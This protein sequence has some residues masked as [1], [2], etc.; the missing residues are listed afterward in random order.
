MVN[1][2]E[3]NGLFEAI[4][5]NAALL[6]ED[7]NA[8]YEHGK[9]IKD[10]AV[11]INAQT[12]MI[13][14]DAVEVNRLSQAMMVSL[15]HLSANLNEMVKKIASDTK[16]IDEMLL[17][18][19]SIDELKSNIEN[20]S[21]Q[22][23]LLALNASIEAARA[24][25]AG[26]GFAVVANEIQK[27]S[28]QSHEATDAI[29]KSI[30]EVKLSSDTIQVNIKLLGKDI[31]TT[32]VDLEQMSQNMVLVEECQKNELKSVKEIGSATQ[33]QE[34]NVEKLYS[35]LEDVERQ[36]IGIRSSID[37]SIDALK[38]NS[39]NIIKLNAI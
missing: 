13:Q 5:K 9:I 3:I 19:K 2:D 28:Q 6:E 34:H 29:E 15:N 16:R 38:Y 25:E 37:S 33:V 39:E 4:N 11:I 30:D 22:I 26:K 21:D 7:A 20:V 32:L 27:L 35:S 1:L 14:N 17:S 24:G 12:E 8:I 10:D 31:N 36:I 23:D 18:V